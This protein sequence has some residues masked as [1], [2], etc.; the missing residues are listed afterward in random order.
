MTLPNEWVLLCCAVV[1]CSSPRST[2]PAWSI[3]PGQSAGAVKPTSSEGDLVAAYGQEAVET[4]RIELGEGETAPG[5]LLFPK[6]STR[7]VEVIW[8]DTVARANSVRLVW[9]GSQ[10]QWQL[11]GGLSLGSSLKEI[12]TRNG[13]PFTLAGFGWDYGG[14]VVDWASGTLASTLP[15]VRLYLDPG[16]A[17]YQSAPYSQVLGD[18]DYS[19]SNQHMQ[20]LN[21]KVY[22]IFMDFE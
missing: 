21:P 17:H 16:P 22:Q 18:R 10:S 3:V 13:R 2:D 20:S 19:S 12:E 5:T 11:P 8:R 6:D 15:G 4:S 9:R 7:R 1:G 14:V